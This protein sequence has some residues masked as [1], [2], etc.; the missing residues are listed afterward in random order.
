MIN[1]YIN[2]FRPLWFS[3]YRCWWYCQIFFLIFFSSRGG[4]WYSS[5]KSTHPIDWSLIGFQMGWSWKDYIKP[6]YFRWYFSLI[7]SGCKSSSTIKIHYAAS[8]IERVFLCS[9]WFRLHNDYPFSRRI[10]SSSFCHSFC[11]KR[12]Q[13]WFWDRTAFW[14]WNGWQFRARFSCRYSWVPPQWSESLEVWGS[15]TGRIV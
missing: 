10:F 8:I 13:D 5:Q 2:P 4:S 3:W 9:R 6:W 12:R 14:G 7:S 1:H 11:R 15:R